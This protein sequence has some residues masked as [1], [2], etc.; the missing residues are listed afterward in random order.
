VIEE[1]IAKLQEAFSQGIL[2]QTEYEEKVSDLEANIRQKI[3][4]ERHLQ[5]NKTKIVKLKEAL[6]SGVITQAEFE[7]KMA[8]L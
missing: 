3:L 6:K 4:Q 5:R 2:N 7:Q 1:K 8:N